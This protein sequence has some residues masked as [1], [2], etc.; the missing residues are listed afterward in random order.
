MSSDTPATPEKL[1]SLLVVEDPD[2]RDVV[3][4]FVAG[5][6]ERLTELRQ[7]HEQ[8]DWELLTTLAHR[9]KGA[10]GSYGY[11]DI[12]RLCAD[13]ERN[14]RAHQGADFSEYLQRLAA[15]TAA[16]KAGL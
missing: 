9:L 16:A 13:M 8:M 12:S 3:E 5:L 6:H 1:V 15:L 4:E 11:P 14:F 2:M 10:G 7:A